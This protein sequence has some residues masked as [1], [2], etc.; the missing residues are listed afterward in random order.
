LENGGLLDL[1]SYDTEAECED[2]CHKVIDHF[3]KCEEG[4]PVCEKK[5]LPEDWAQ[6]RGFPD[7]S[8]CEQAARNNSGYLIGCGQAMCYFC[9]GDPYYLPPDE[10]SAE[11]GYA[12]Q[13]DLGTNCVWCHYCENGRSYSNYRSASE[14]AS[15]GGSDDVNE[16]NYPCCADRLDTTCTW[17]WYDDP[18][19]GMYGWY[20]NMTCESPKKTCDQPSFDGT[21]G[22]TATT[23]CYCL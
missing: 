21:N 5:Y 23:D 12:D 17:Y 20:G 18:Q 13:N 3:G 11:G 8:S 14:C 1:K 19:Q 15:L 10:C 7:I 2:E 22:Q 16:G 6:G 4:W 9:D